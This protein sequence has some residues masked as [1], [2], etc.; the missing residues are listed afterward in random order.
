M[1]HLAIRISF[2]IFSF[3]FNGILDILNLKIKHWSREYVDLCTFYN[4]IMYKD[5]ILKY[6]VY[7]LNKKKMH[8]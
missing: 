4:Q 5:K 1:S 3:K 6:N 7:F 2:I 8:D